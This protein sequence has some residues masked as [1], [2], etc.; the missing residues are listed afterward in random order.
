MKDVASCDKP[1]VG[2]N[3]RRPGDLRMGQPVSSH[4][5][6]FPTEYIGGLRPT[7]GS[8]TSQY[9]QEE[10]AIAIPRVAASEKGRV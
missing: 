6:T 10:K 4:V 5:D 7:K 8:E 1:R 2:A 9:L 3:D